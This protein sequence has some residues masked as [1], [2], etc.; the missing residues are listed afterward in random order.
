MCFSLKCYCASIQGS[1]LP[2][3]KGL[4]AAVSKDTKTH[5][6]KLNCFNVSSIH[7]LLSARSREVVD[8][9]ASSSLERSKKKPSMVSPINEPKK[10][11]LFWQTRVPPLHGY[12]ERRGI[13]SDVSFWANY[14]GDISVFPWT[15][16]GGHKC[17][18]GQTTGWDTLKFFLLISPAMHE[19]NLRKP[20][21]LHL[22]DWFAALGLKPF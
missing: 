20:F 18:P 13:S 16:R 8:I 22:R 17:L 7:A 14:G 21:S 11:L 3:P 15:L 5:L 10:E 9:A 1:E 4:L 6:A 12:N 2:N 19:T